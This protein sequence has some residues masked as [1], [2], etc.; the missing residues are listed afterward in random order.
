MN[1]CVLAFIQITICQ[2]VVG[3]GDVTVS[4]VR[5]LSLQ[6]MFASL[7]NCQLYDKL[8]QFQNYYYLYCFR[9][10]IIVL[11]LLVISANA[12]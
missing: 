10:F 8:S 11:T 12:I 7:V 2:S 4:D 9:F 5:D 1:E 6:E 3:R